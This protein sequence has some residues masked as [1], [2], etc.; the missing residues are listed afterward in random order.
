MIGNR[1]S[2]VIQQNIEALDNRGGST[3]DRGPRPPMKNLP[4]SGPHFGPASLD[5]H[6]N[7]PVISLIQLHIVPPA[8]LPQLE[9]C[10]PLPSP[11]WLVPEPPLLDNISSFKPNA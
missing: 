4:P 2:D 3:G 1:R 11:I 5:F 6:L 10:P 9:L 8:L 7:A